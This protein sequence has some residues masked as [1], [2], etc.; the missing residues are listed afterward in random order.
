[1]KNT[2]KSTLLA[3]KKLK[4][5]IFSKI[6]RSNS[7]IFLYDVL[8]KF[9]HVTH[10]SESAQHFFWLE[11]CWWPM[12]SHFGCSKIAALSFKDI[13]FWDKYFFFWNCHRNLNFK[14][15]PA[16]YLHKIQILMG[17]FRTKIYWCQKVTFS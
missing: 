11:S 9:G 13:S 17:I 16:K 14:L 2:S 1:M 15:F 8:L 7:K 4:I 10:I 5:S 3:C 6:S 12:W